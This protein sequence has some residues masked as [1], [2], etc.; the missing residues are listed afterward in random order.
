M[1]NPITFSVIIWTR[2]NAD[3]LNRCL[4]SLIEQSGVNLEII[5]VDCDS[6]DSTL[7][8]AK[9]YKC[10][11]IP[12]PIGEIP[13]NYSKSLN[14]GIKKAS[15]ST[16]LAISSHVWLP[17]HNTLIW[18]AKSLYN[19][20]SI[21]AVSLSRSKDH[22]KL[23]EAVPEP[24]F[25]VISKDNFNGEGMYNYCSLFRKADWEIRPFNEDLP[26]CEDQEWILY[27][28]NKK[29]SSSIIFKY[30]LAGY[31]NPNYNA[32]KDIQEYY[33]MGKYIF[34]YYS[35]FSFIGSLYLNSI[36]RLNKKQLSKAKHYLTVANSLLKYKFFPPK[37]IQSDDYLKK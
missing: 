6:K 3:V 22:K 34:P 28:M 25:L 32:A 16:V 20:D 37:S 24:S 36:Q 11:I 31:D 33:V 35:S 30:P 19:N 8:I 13:F 15:C 7:S 27:W 29:N 23:I 4:N 14:L 10:L 21:K 1:D 18:M 2:N 12:Y 17:N 5:V 26:T 9:E